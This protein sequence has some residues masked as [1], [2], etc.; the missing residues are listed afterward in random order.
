M[1]MLTYNWPHDVCTWAGAASDCANYWTAWSAVATALAVAV[2]LLIP[3]GM[4]IAEGRRRKADRRAVIQ[5]V[6]SAVDQ[7]VAYHGILLALC[8]AKPVYHEG[9]AACDRIGSNAITL[10]QMLAVLQSRSE[11]T[12]GAVYSAIGGQRIAE[13]VIPN[14]T[15]PYGQTTNDWTNRA[16]RLADVQSLVDAVALRVGGVRRHAGLSSSS[17]A[18]AI[19]AKY[20]PIVAEIVAALAANRG[21]VIGP[22][23]ADHY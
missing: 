17:S 11:L 1:P 5:E 7:I 22:L 4:T 12:D 8:R 21:P 19:R 18:A 2:A 6:C 10:A 13:V 23:D 16:T 3:I 15:G 14:G 20:D 9:F